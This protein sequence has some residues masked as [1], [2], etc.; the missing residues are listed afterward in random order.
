MTKNI[1]IVLS[2]TQ[3]KVGKFIR[4]FTKSEYNHASISLNKELTQM[5]SFARLSVANPLVGGMICENPNYL[6][7][8]TE[9]EVVVKVFEIPVSDIQYSKIASFV[10]DRYKDYDGYYYNLIGF[11]G[12]FFKRQWKLYKTY[13]CSEFVMEALQCGGL[14]YSTKANSLVTPKD[15]NILL[16]DYTFYEGSISTYP[17]LLNYSDFLYNVD[18]LYSSDYFIHNGF[19]H[20]FIRSISHFKMLLVRHT[21]NGY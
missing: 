17:Y 4:T 16:K 6:S 20:E 13:I 11:F 19:R 10:H 18:F 2:K 14:S 7:L 21:A 3:S 12:L 15:I 8:G 5:Y 9:N 1:Y